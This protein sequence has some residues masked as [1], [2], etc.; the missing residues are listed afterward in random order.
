M[1]ACHSDAT[2]GSMKPFSTIL[3]VVKTM[4]GWKQSIW[5]FVRIR[6][7]ITTSNQAATCNY[8]MAHLCHDSDTY[9]WDAKHLELNVRLQKALRIQKKFGN[10]QIV[11]FVRLF[12]I[13]KS[14]R[15]LCLRIVHRYVK[16]HLSETQLLAF[17][18][19]PFIICHRDRHKL[20]IVN[21]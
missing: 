14:E 5:L 17:S 8:W 16:R 20:I 21:M 9:F 18:L 3:L 1:R 11:C 15:L 10:P 7:G 6:L 12:K 13:S 19:T 2:A 4:M